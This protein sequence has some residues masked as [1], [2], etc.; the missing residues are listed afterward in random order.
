MDLNKVFRPLTQTRS[1]PKYKFMTDDELQEAVEA[2]ENDAK[3]LL[4]MPPF[5]P[6]R[7]P[8]DEVLSEDPV[9]EGV[10]TANY[11][12]T[13]I[14]Y[15]VPHR[16]R[17]IVVREPSGTLRKATWNER[18]RMIQIYFPK[19]GRRVI[20][21]PLFKEENLQVLFKNDQ[22]YDVL[23]RCTCQFEPDSHEFIKIFRL[24]YED[25]DKHGKY[26]LLRSTKFFGGLAWY[27]CSCRRIDGLL[28]EM[29]QRDLIHDAARLVC[30]FNLVHPQSESAQHAQS[31]QAAD[32]DL[33]KIYSQY[34]SERAGFIELAIQNYENMASSSSV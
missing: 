29:L 20:P 6:E 33:L 1:T 3:G 30:L 22:H 15:A 4:K 25:I 34:E 31:K 5:L 19:E 21:P 13:D 14:T 18:D 10:E 2:A 8:I 26:D 32:L 7:K 9:L 23:H 24:A 11:V 27:L 28:V 16:E 12:F 17:F